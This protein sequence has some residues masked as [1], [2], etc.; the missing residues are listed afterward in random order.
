MRGGK[1]PRNH[2]EWEEVQEHSFGKHFTI[3]WWKRNRVG[4]G[5]VKK[6]W[7]NINDRGP[8]CILTFVQ[9]STFPL[10]YIGWGSSSAWSAVSPP[11]PIWRVTAI[12]AQLKCL[13]SL[14][15]LWCHS[16]MDLLFSVLEYAFVSLSLHRL[17]AIMYYI[18]LYVLHPDRYVHALSR[19]FQSTSQKQFYYGVFLCDLWK[20]ERISTS[21]LLIPLS[22][23]GVVKFRGIPNIVSEIFWFK[24]IFIDLLIVQ[25]LNLIQRTGLE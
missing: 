25:K 10:L 23:V 16:W 9:I 2:M 5:G 24:I 14:N 18:Y 6:V 4:N 22:S 1:Q 12:G 13:C 7:C 15:L 17:H 3:T 11:L 8:W 19:S 21:K 20:F